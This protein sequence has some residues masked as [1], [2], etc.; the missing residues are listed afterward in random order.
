MT[1]ERLS[2]SEQQQARLREKLRRELGSDVLDALADP[3][4]IEIML[5]PDGRLWIDELGV[6]MRDTGT[7]ITA[8]QGENLLGTIAAMLGCVITGERP[9]LECELPL[10]GSRLCGILP[11]VVLGP[12]FCIRK[13]A[14]SVFTLDEYVCEG[15]LDGAGSTVAVRED[16]VPDRG[17]VAML[18][19]AIRSRQ[20]ILVIGGT[21]SG[22]TT[23]T[24]GL[25]H[26]LDSIVGATQRVIVI[27]DTRELRCTVPNTVALRTTENIDM[28]RLV[29]TALRL[30]P[31]RIVIGEV[32]GPEALA[33]LKAW[34]TG[35]P[36]G[37]ATV[38]ANDAH[39][40]LI[41]LEHLVQEAGVPPQPALIAEAIDLL[42]VIVRTPRGRRV[43]EIARVRGVSSSGYVLEH[44]DPEHSY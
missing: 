1:D 19:Y 31:D 39:A 23:L 37:I 20:N 13:P 40:G 34:N 9:I 27:E 25:L 7:R 28:T 17:H 21:Q 11:P 22:K 12:T 29:R 18:R 14:A 38:H 32:R 41:R 5:N 30:R 2:L 36:G 4:V 6:G 35:H 26:E 33:M 3:R 10:D 24:N 8:A 44:V 16:D 42:V 43:T 15:V